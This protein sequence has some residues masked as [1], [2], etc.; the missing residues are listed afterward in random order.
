MKFDG[1]IIGAGHFTRKNCDRLN[2]YLKE[3]EKLN[4]TVLFAG[5]LGDYKYYNMDQ[6]VIRALGIFEKIA[7]PS[8]IPKKRDYVVV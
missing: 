3:A 2:L 4:G 1:S 5:R 7:V 6:A 8:Y